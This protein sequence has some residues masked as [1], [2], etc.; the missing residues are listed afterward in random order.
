[1]TG[2][3][4]FEALGSLE[5]RKEDLR[6]SQTAALAGPHDLLAVRAEY[7]QSV[8]GRV[9]RNPQCFAALL[10]HHE[11]IVV[12]LFAACPGPVIRLCENEALAG[13]VPEWAPIEDWVVRNRPVL[14]AVGLHHA[15][16]QVLLAVF[17]P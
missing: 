15:D 5:I 13:R 12:G 14:A 11:E 17:A 3:G 16:L 7:R 9:E 8:E 6:L 4:S 10:L 1:M 2:A